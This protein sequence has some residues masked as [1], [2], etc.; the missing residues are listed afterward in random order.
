MT[1]FPALPS[2]VPDTVK[3]EDSQIE[4]ALTTDD[5]Y[6]VLVGNVEDGQGAPEVRIIHDP[7]HHLH[8][9]PQGSVHLSGILSAEVAR[10]WKFSRPAEEDDQ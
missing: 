1:V 9:Q 10:S 8:P 2:S 4:R 7:L 6:L 3:L 5:F